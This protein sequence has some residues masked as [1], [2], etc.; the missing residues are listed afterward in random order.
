MDNIVLDFEDGA[1]HEIAKLAAACNL[2][3]EEI[4]EMVKFGLEDE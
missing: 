2:G 1:Y 4:L 3:K